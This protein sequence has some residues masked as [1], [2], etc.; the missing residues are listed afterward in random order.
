MQNFS[1]NVIH[2]FT[3]YKRHKVKRD[4]KVHKTQQMLV[5]MECDRFD[6]LAPV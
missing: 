2:I 6:A 5:A 3:I 4:N 1:Q